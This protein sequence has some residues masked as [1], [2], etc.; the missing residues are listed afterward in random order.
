MTL[1][2][3]E[4]GTTG[5][6]I[7][8]VGL[9]N[10]AI[11]GPRG[12]WG[13]GPQDDDASVRTILAAVEAGVTW[14]D[15]AAAYGLGH[16]EVVLGRAL[17]ALP[18][19]DRPLVFTKCG[20]AWDGSTTR[21]VGRP[22]ALRAELELSTRRLG[23]DVVDVYQ[24][25]WPPEDGTDLRDAWATLL[26]FRES[27]RIRFAGVS[28]VDASQLAQLE[29]I[30]HVDSVQPPLSLLH[31]EALG[32][33][34]Q[35]REAGTGVLCY[36]PMQAG[37]LTGKYDRDAIAALARDDWRRSDPQFNDPMLGRALDL[38]SG[39]RAVASEVGITLAEL[40]IA[41]VLAHVGVTGAVV[42]ARQPDQIREWIGAGEVQLDAE[43][44][45]KIAHLIRDSAAG[46]GP[47]P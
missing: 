22:D 11:G 30:G 28:N 14:I 10:W 29:E 18:E 13:W 36:S 23:T 39:L 21:R 17:A 35:A 6:C 15:T 42:G 19:E 3:R 26:E 1:A 5:L 45:E 2:K 12:E 46:I 37:L 33:I 43:V 40:A 4:L 47:I 38:L 20:L 44:L 27:G 8:T 25:H 9:G 34:S 41:W 31:R 16:A 32:L 7:S 24:L